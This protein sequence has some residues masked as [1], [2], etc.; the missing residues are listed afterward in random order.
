MLRDG[1]YSAWFKTTVG[2]GTGIVHLA[3]GTVVG[4]DTVLAYAGSY[5]IDGNRFTAVIK[6]NRHAPG[7][8]SV[9]GL[10]DL[11]LRLKGSSNGTVAHCSGFADEAPELPFEVTLLLSVSED[12]APLAPPQQPLKFKPK[13][14]P[15]SPRKR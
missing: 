6:T 3:A 11:S 8:P 14:L 9:F 1:T 12:T 4:R 5:E 2:E 15:M 13:T 10:D 7:Q